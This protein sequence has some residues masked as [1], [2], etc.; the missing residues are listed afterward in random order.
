MTEASHD[1]AGLAA[2]LGHRFA[3]PD[4]LA[5]AV[6]HPSVGGL[7]RPVRGGR[8]GAK[9]AGTATRPAGTAYERLEFLG[10]RVLGL[11]IATWLLQRHPDEAEGDL[12]RRHAA[13][14]RREA[15]AEVAAALDLGRYL[16]LS[17]GEDDQGGRHNHAILADCCE[18]VIGALYLDGGLGPAE[19][20][21]RRCWA[22]LVERTAAPPRD[23]KTALQ[24]WA[25]GQ[26][27]PLP[28]YEMLAR[29]G[30]DHE[31]QFEVQVTV[32]GVAPVVASA[33]SKRAAEK[34]A[35]TL[36]LQQ[37]GIASHV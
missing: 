1:L 4:L 6:T 8:A 32:A 15:L 22:V 16:R 14:V 13:L 26:G 11:A 33:G 23:P 9:G 31:P 18:A 29:S 27:K 34:L 25:Q 7:A 21:I 5:D 24:E 28:V 36:L 35:A 2:R 17:P 19:A 3:R 12:A 30:P 10:D 20:L 37:V